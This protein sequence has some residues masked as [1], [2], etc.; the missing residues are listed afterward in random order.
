MP[1]KQLNLQKYKVERI[2]KIKKL[3]PQI[4]EEEA[5]SISDQDEDDEESEEE[6]KQVPTVIKKAKNVK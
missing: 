3:K 6:K 1:N 4:I 2:I 5:D